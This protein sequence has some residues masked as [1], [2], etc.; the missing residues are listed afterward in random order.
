MQRVFAVGET[1]YDIIFRDHKPVTAQVGGSM[2][3][4]AVSLGRLGLDVYFISEYGP[5]SDPVGKL[6]NEFLAYN[7]VNT[8]LSNR[9]EDGKSTIS[10]AFLDENKNA[11]YSFYKNPPYNRLNYPDFPINT[12]DIVL[13][14]SFYS[15]DR[16]IRPVLIKILEKASESGAIIIYDP[17]FRSPHLKELPSLKPIILENLKFSNIIRGSDEDF[18]FIFNSKSVD[19]AYKHINKE[20]KAALIYTKNKNGVELISLK[21]KLHLNVPDLLPVS[22]I[23][24]GDN[25]NAG[26]IWTIVMEGI[27][28][29]NIEDL[30]EKQWTRILN[31]GIRFASDVCMSYE[32]YISKE[33]AKEIMSE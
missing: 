31:N 20:S 33:F 13:F 3:N 4:T 19:D 24:A 28:R 8:E 16:E 1:V 22:T 23:G 26:L 15:L 2:L 21:K 29:K 6:I 11:S 25:F 10:L 17:N 12:N 14:G 32:N 9:S 30:K 7:L 5:D 18:H 27:T